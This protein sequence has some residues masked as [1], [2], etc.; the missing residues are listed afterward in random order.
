MLYGIFLSFFVVGRH[1]N[2]HMLQTMRGKSIIE[3]KRKSWIYYFYVQVSFQDD[4]YNQPQFQPYMGNN[5]EFGVG[6]MKNE[7][8]QYLRIIPSFQSREKFLQVCP[9]GSIPFTHCKI[10]FFGSIARLGLSLS[11]AAPPDNWY[12]R[13]SCHTIPKISFTLPLTMSSLPAWTKIKWNVWKFGTQSSIA[14]SIDCTTISCGI[15]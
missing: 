6:R 9:A 2:K 10:S 12:L 7:S 5:G 8:E 11:W 14:F 15:I 1:L 13:I 3:L 4:S